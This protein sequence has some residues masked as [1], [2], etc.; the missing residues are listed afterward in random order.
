LARAKNTASTQQNGYDVVVVTT[1]S[2]RKKAGK[3][4]DLA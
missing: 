4:A 3:I 1:A 2:Q